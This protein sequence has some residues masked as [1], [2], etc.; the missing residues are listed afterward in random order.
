MPK[1]KWDKVQSNLKNESVFISEV[2]LIKYGSP[3]YI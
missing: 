1:E 3:Y 2:L